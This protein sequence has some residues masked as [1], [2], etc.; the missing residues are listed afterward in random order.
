M[1][2]F[3]Q[4][5]AI[6]QDKKLLSAVF[7]CCKTSLLS[8]CRRI[9]L[10]PSP[11]RSTREPFRDSNSSEHLSLQLEIM[12]CFSASTPLYFSCRHVPF[13]SSFHH[14]DVSPFSFL[15]NFFC[16][17]PCRVLGFEGLGTAP[18]SG[19]TAAGRAL[20]RAPALGPFP[21]GFGCA[22]LQGLRGRSVQGFEKP[23]ETLTATSTICLPTWGTDT[24][25]MSPGQK[26]PHSPQG[27]AGGIVPP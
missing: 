21:R 7:W 9:S 5:M 19:G 12:S 18:G 4:C 10:C 24:L 3:L 23:H 1:G 20:P 2:Q 17:S 8:T 15:W 26:S 16:F 11:R 13:S 6:F 25:E 22:R 27:L 14:P